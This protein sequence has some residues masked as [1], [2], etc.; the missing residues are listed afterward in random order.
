MTK[1]LKDKQ[2]EKYLIQVIK[3]WDL[4]PSEMN[5][6]YK[7]QQKRNWY[8]KDIDL[9]GTLYD[10][11]DEDFAKV[12]EIVQMGEEV[13][14]VVWTVDKITKDWKTSRYLNK[15]KEITRIWDDATIELLENF[16]EIDFDLLK[17]R[18]ENYRA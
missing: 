11:S 7:L 1:M 12:K 10:V 14:S 8:W 9:S 18:V 3:D 17:E 13:S 6:I 15:A 2:K 4:Y 5:H 16:I